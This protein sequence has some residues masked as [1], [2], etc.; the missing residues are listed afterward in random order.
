MKWYRTVRSLGR[1]FYTLQLMN[2]VSRKIWHIFTDT[3]LQ[4]VPVLPSKERY[5]VCG[6]RLVKTRKILFSK[7]LNTSSSKKRSS[8]VIFFQNGIFFLNFDKK[9][10]KVVC[11]LLSPT[12]A[13]G[14]GD[15]N[16]KI[17]RLLS[18]QLL[19]VPLLL[20]PHG[21]VGLNRHPR[22]LVSDLLKYR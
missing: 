2:M 22:V 18:T 9:K 14:V 8:K 12:S 17:D 20:H 15:D 11:L 19:K 1:L 16:P 10:S 7:Q 5:Q 13:A 6:I 4:Y 3:A 21:A